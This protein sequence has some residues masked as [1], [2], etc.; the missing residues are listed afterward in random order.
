MQV[1]KV[2][3]SILLPVVTVCRVRMVGMAVRSGNGDRSNDSIK[4]TTE[5]L[6]Y[7]TGNGVS[8]IALFTQRIFSITTI[9]AGC[10]I[11]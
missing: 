6:K 5:I 11:T 4:I 8:I 1:V 3:G 9:E 10:V 2:D 7:Q